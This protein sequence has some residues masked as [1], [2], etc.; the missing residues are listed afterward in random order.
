MKIADLDH[1]FTILVD[2]VNSVE[3]PYVEN[4]ALEDRDP[5]RILV[6]T[7]L[8]ARTKDAVTA[9]ASRNLFASAVTPQEMISLGERKIS[10]L[11]YPVGFFR[12]KA[13]SLVSLSKQ[14]IETFNAE[15]PET[16]DELIKLDGIGRKTANLVLTLGFQKKGI[17]VDTHVH[18]IVNRWGLC[19]STTPFETEMQL[20]SILPKKFWIPINRLL[21]LYGQTLCKPISPWCSKC[22][23]STYCNRRG[24]FKC[25]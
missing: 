20:R 6:A 10:E 1:A 11:I 8:S 21:V 12:N 13:R 18:R 25:R 24:V 23:I 9:K 17:C 14:L 5:F 2:S 7:L 16:I 19:T 3:N 22:R 4:L 15:V